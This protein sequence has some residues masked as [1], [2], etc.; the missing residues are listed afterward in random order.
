MKRIFVNQQ[1][2]E[3]SHNHSGM[4]KPPATPA[5]P[6]LPADFFGSSQEF[7][8]VINEQLAKWLPQLAKFAKSPIS[9]VD[10]RA[11]LDDSGVPD[12]CRPALAQHLQQVRFGAGVGV[13]F[14]GSQ[15]ER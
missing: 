10:L 12:I 15:Y 7:S 13:V 5:S 14:G 2:A 11:W 9:R 3:E 8:K 1:L 6:A 4:G